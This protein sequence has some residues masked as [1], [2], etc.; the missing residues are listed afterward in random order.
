MATPEARTS[1]SSTLLKDEHERLRLQTS[2]ADF[3]LLAHR[4]TPSVSSISNR[5][6]P[7]V[8]GFPE[9]SLDENRG[10]A[11]FGVKAGIYLKTPFWM[12]TLF[13]IGLFSAVGHHTFYTSLNGDQVGSQSQ[14]EW[15]LR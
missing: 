5:S 7:D 10:W 6:H 9:R 13:F 11:H 8:D 1:Q 12:V 2:T 14:Q 15:N 4:K 3:S